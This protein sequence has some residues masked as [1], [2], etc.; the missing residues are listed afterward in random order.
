ML[1]KTSRHQIP[2]LHV[3]PLTTAFHICDTSLVG[4][5]VHNGFLS[6]CNDTLIVQLFL[7][8]L[9]TVG[10]ASDSKDRFRVQRIQLR[11][12]CF[13][14]HEE[15]ITFQFFCIICVKLLVLCT[16]GIQ[17]WNFF[18]PFL[19]CGLVLKVRGFKPQQT[20]DLCRILSLQGGGFAGLGCVPPF[21][22][23]W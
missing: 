19:A 2:R 13:R 16:V 8:L 12:M 21:I 22:S 6:N 23:S 14:F 3:Q 20:Y 10:H 11:D 1:N 5:K 4:F 15:S 9:G 7:T 17:R 18:T